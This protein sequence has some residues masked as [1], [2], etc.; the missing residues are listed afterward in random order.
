MESP[1]E[2]KY[3]SDLSPSILGK[4]PLNTLYDQPGCPKEVQSDKEEDTYEIPSFRPPKEDTKPSSGSVA[5][6]YSGGVMEKRKYPATYQDSSNKRSNSRVGYNKVKPI[7]K[8]GRRIAYRGVAFMNKA[9]ITAYTLQQW[10]DDIYCEGGQSDVILGEDLWLHFG[11][12]YTSMYEDIMAVTQ[13]PSCEFR[14]YEMNAAMLKWN[15]DKIDVK[16]KDV[17]YGNEVK[18]AVVSIIDHL[19]QDF[20]N[21]IVAGEHLWEEYGVL[22]RKVDQVLVCINELKWPPVKTDIL[23]MQSLVWEAAM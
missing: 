18:D 20:T 6:H 13:K 3:L 9:T 10:M 12:K 11:D 16:V 19:E 21:I 17:A 22:Q 7:L 23:Q 5:V 15:E 8:K 4:S 14:K 2:D 1:I